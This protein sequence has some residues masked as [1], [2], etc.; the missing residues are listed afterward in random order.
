MTAATAASDSLPIVASDLGADRL[1]NHLIF[2]PEHAAAHVIGRYRAPPDRE[3]RSALD[4]RRLR[5]ANAPSVR[6]TPIYI[7]RGFNKAHYSATWIDVQACTP[8]PSASTE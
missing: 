4:V 2:V 8:Y 3:N 5:R 6:K 7:R 1:R